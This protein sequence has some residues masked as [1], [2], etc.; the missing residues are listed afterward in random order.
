MELKPCPF[1]GG[2][3]NLHTTVRNRFYVSAYIMCDKCGSSSRYF[4]DNE[5]DGT[6]IFKAIKEWNMRADNEPCPE[7][8]C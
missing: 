1:C 6:F 2:K 7:V 3:A 8:Y 5:N 4:D